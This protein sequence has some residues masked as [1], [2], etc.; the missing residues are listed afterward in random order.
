MWR[1]MATG[2]LIGAAAA[3]IG[4]AVWLV[5]GKLRRVEEGEQEKQWPFDLDELRGLMDTVIE[6]QQEI[7]D[8][9]DGR[10][11]DRARSFLDYYQR[12]RAA[13]S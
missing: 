11:R 3:A 12:R 7:I 9:L 8:G 6:Q 1:R 10:S 13:A 4:G 5:V 2:I